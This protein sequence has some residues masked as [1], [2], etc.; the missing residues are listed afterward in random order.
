MIEEYN[1]LKVNNSDKI[2]FIRRG[3]FYY[4]LFR[5][6]YIISYL[7][8][9]KVINDKL[10]FPI[11][12]INKVCKKLRELDIG[13]VVDNDIEYG[14]SEIYNMYLKLG[15][16]RVRIN[17]LINDINK[18]LNKLDINKLVNIRDKLYEYDK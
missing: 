18:I 3:C 14:D 17:Y 10:S 6:S 15:Y 12:N 16:D 2:V 13:Y 9:Y 5:D 4:C 11:N 1:Y 8:D 7:F